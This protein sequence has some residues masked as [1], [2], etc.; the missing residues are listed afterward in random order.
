MAAA[1]A[2]AAAADGVPDI[3]LSLAESF[4]SLHRNSPLCKM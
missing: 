3:I 1:A 4:S 2:A